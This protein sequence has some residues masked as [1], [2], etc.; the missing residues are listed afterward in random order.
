[1]SIDCG[2]NAATSGYNLN[3]AAGRSVFD[4]RAETDMRVVDIGITEQ[5]HRIVRPDHTG[6]RRKKNTSVAHSFLYKKHV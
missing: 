1:M 5:N 4:L 2:K 6:N 3:P